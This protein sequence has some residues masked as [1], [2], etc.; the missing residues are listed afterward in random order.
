MPC[1]KRKV[2]CQY[3]PP[4]Q[5]LFESEE[6]KQGDPL[7]SVV[8]LSP[9]SSLQTPWGTSEETRM[10]QFFLDKVGPWF[11]GYGPFEGPMLW[12]G[13]VPRTAS[14]LPALKHLLT[15]VAFLEMPI[16]DATPAMIRDRS[17]TI[18]RHYTHGVHELTK[19]QLSSAES[20]LGPVLAWLIETL[21]FN[22]TRAR[23]H[24]RG[25][26]LLHAKA[27]QE[28]QPSPDDFLHDDKYDGMLAYMSMFHCL[29]AKVAPHSVASPST[30]AASNVDD[31]LYGSLHML[32]TSIRPVHSSTA[33]AAFAHYF[34][35]VH[36]LAMSATQL[37]QARA[38]ILHWERIVLQNKYLTREASLIFNAL[39]LLCNLASILLP[40][41]LVVESEVGVDT[42][43]EALR[44]VLGRCAWMLTL[45]LERDTEEDR[46][47]LRDTVELILR[48]VRKHASEEEA[49]EEA[50]RML[51]SMN[52]DA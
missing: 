15:A 35:R 46:K 41:P 47:A 26:K 23:M 50:E 42:M 25:A 28:N 4:K 34:A 40:V 6:P 20:A 18:M 38:Y 48:C 45:R 2:I 51:G 17:Q 36:S 19:P 30:G 1:T 12:A 24:L 43:A 27:R 44:Y 9:P 11:C 37:A 13:A 32:N 16:P 33:R 52:V 14:S 3:S 8:L 10:Q 49:R 7:G 31:G 21:S 22:E 5:W 29:R 39:H